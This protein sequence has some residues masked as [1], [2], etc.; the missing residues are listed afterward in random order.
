MPGSLQNK[1]QQHE[2]APPP[3]VWGKIAMQLDNEFVPGDITTSLKLDNAAITPP[4]DMWDKIADDLRGNDLPEKEKRANIIPLIYKKLAVAALIIGAIAVAGLYFFN[5]E[6]SQNR[7]VK[8]VPSKQ[9]S[10]SIEEYKTPA[11][12]GN[13]SSSPVAV[14]K[15][16]YK[17]RRKYAAE[18][19]ATEHD[20]NYSSS[21]EQA[22]LYDLQTVSALQPVAVSAPPLRDKKGNIIFDASL[23]SKPDDEYI[24][25][26]GP[27]GKQTRISNKFLSCL[28]YINSNLTSNETDP[29]GIRC[30]MQFEEWRKKILSESAFIPTANNFFDI[31]EL[32]D[33][34]A[35]M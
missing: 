30:K 29:R 10:P 12:T 33:L 5:N 34:I 35:E 14:I 7:I 22:P 18:H 19:A 17:P 11:K 6:P 32:K 8:T 2:V 28:S 21:P 31:F 13:T 9:G 24:T 1:L 20:I 3:S 4:S 26:T 16:E 23:I 25:V 27:N 15:N